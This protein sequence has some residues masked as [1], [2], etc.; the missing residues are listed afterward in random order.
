MGE[1]K[2]TC[3]PSGKAL[4]KQTKL[5]E[6]QGEKQ[7]KAI[8]EH[9]KQLVESNALVK[10]DYDNENNYKFLLKQIIYMMRLLLK[11]KMK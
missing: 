9:G 8:K 1:T 7:I 3:S 5:I 10:N 6:N 4:E 11:E 2:F